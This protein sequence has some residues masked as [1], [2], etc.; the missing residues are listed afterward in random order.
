M[1]E[2]IEQILCPFLFPPTGKKIFSIYIIKTHNNV[3]NRTKI[4]IKKIYQQSLKCINIFILILYYS[5]KQKQESIS[6]ISY[7]TL[8][9]RKLLSLFCWLEKKFESSSSVL[10]LLGFFMFEVIIFQSPLFCFY[11]R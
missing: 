5:L 10:L 3:L 7:Q 1:Y 6:N 2:L 11:L 8:H 9:E 4:I